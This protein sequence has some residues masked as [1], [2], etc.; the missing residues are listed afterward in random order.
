M[1][2]QSAA[3]CSQADGT[4]ICTNTFIEMFPFSS[5]SYRGHP[6]L[7]ACLQNSREGLPVSCNC[8][9]GIFLSILSVSGLRT[10]GCE[11][12]MITEESFTCSVRRQFPANARHV[13]ISTVVLVLHPWL[14]FS[15]VLWLRPVP[16]TTGM[17][18]PSFDWCYA[19]SW[20]ILAGLE[21][22]LSFC[23]KDNFHFCHS[24]PQLPKF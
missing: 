11:K 14:V 12:Q 9:T 18:T 2:M 17:F 24:L 10:G 5:K 4:P 20:W 8:W 21:I 3:G 22:P 23:R 15:A 1:Y 16:A 19:S 7:S 6:V 13:H